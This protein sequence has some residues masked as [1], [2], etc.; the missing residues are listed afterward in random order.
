MLVEYAGKNLADF[1]FD[2]FPS[3][4][5][6]ACSI[7]ILLSIHSNLIM[8]VKH[9]LKIAIYIVVLCKNWVYP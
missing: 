1:I 8:H 9:L 6:Y 5:T 7:D 3:K 2:T 4:K